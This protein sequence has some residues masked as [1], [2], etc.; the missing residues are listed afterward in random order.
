M[1]RPE[2]VELFYSARVGPEGV[3]QLVPFLS[4]RDEWILSAA[5]PQ[6]LG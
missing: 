3:D 5:Y 4:P 1:E 6:T 2:I